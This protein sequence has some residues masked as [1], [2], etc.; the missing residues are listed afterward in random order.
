MPRGLTTHLIRRAGVG[1]L[2]LW[3]AAASAQPAPLAAQDAH[4]WTLQTQG[5]DL[6]VLVQALAEASGSRVLGPAEAL[7]GSTLP[8]RRGVTRTATLDAAWARLLDG[9]V[10]HARQCSGQGTRQRCTLWLVAAVSPATG[11]G[12]PPP[13]AAWPQSDPPGL[14]PSSSEPE[15]QP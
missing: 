14:F 2:A 13:A 10:S 5:Q 3:A 11:G 9:R 7:R 6:A 4:G 1:M 12:M 8:L 15:P